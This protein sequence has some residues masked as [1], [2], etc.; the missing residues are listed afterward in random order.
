MASTPLYKSLKQNGT[1]FYAFP[2]ASEDISAAYQ[3]SNYKMYFSKFALL[4]FPKQNLTAGSGSQ[5]RAVT[6]DFE[7]SFSKS[8]NAVPSTNFNDAIVESLRNYVANQET[9]VRE[10][11]LN[12]NQYYYNTNALGTVTEKLFFKWC[13]KL[14]IIDLEPAVPGDEYFDGLD[15]LLPV[16]GFDE[17]YFP[18][19]LWREREIINWDTVKF[20]ESTETGY[21]GK[22]EIEFN[23]ETNFRIGDVV[24]LYN[25]SD[26]TINSGNLSGVGTQEG[27]RFRVL[28][29]FD[30]TATTGQRVILDISINHLTNTGTTELDGQAALVYNRLVQYIGEVTGVSNVQEANRSYTEVYAQ[31][32]DHAGQTPDILFRTNIDENYQPGLIFPILASQIQPEILGAQDF[33]SPIVSSPQNYPGSYF[34]QFDTQ[35]F[36]YAVSSGDSLRRSGLF[37]G[38]TGDRVN[39]N[40]SPST[41]D[42]LGIDFDTTHYVR[43][44]IPGREV[45]NFD[46][47]NAMMLDNMPPVDFEFNAILWYYTVEDNNGVSD[48]NLYGISFLDNPGNNVIPGEEG[49]RF[50]GYSKLVSSNMQD[51]TSYAFNLSLNFNIINENLNQVYNPN[52]VNSVFSMNL[53]NEAMTKLSSV[54]DLFLGVVAE[55]Q[56]IGE[57]LMNMKSLLYTQNDITTLNAKMKN[58]EELLRLYSRIQI[59]S[60]DSISVTTVTGNPPSIAL[61][62]VETGYANVV[63]IMTG[64]MYSTQ[65]SVPAR[66]SVPENKNFMINLFNNDTTPFTLPN[67]ERLSLVITGAIKYRQ[68]FEILIRPMD[69][70][71]Q[72]KKLDI[73][74]DDN[75][76]SQNILLLLG[77]IDLPVYYNDVFGQANSA[78]K[79][80]GFDFEIDANSNITLSDGPSLELSLVGNPYLINNSI[81]VGDTLV[82]NN[83]YFGTA[84]VYDFSG[85]YKVTS[86]GGGASKVMTLDLSS[87]VSV[88]DYVATNVASMPMVVQ[89]ANSSM[90]S[91]KPYFSLNKGMRVIITNTNDNAVDPK[92][93]YR[94][95]VVGL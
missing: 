18:E 30:S 54:N 29:T 63:E 22:L 36:T 26:T 67:N 37:Y 72:N 6:F 77:N 28:A 68:S 33:S 27:L 58:L 91:N 13:K 9:V 44:N 65:G 70:S 19:Y 55:Q 61:R 69:T 41:L 14:N 7:G 21:I 31:I 83:F 39:Y 34:G 38:I 50:P 53:F 3:N 89:S 48:T 1:T 5:S 93:K 17:A 20:S 4:N 16:D 74:L 42:G 45:T 62:N 84:S 94:V 88:S 86:M 43:M 56:L 35:D 76:G 15:E 12:N 8:V 40:L 66:I 92:M 47:F 24:R 2:G 25:V 59:N 95:E 80:T 52:S 81:Q 90:L 51:G 60:T 49:I 46:Q 23:G 75:T 57:E 71:T 78:S 10:T 82:L 32:P 87:N 79:W 85:Q 73:Y 11:R 64:K